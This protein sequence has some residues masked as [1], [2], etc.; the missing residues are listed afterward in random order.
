MHF[1][2]R[3]YGDGKPYGYWS[4]SQYRVFMRRIARMMSRDGEDFVNEER[5]QFVERVLVQMGWVAINE[6]Y[7]ALDAII[8]MGRG[9]L[10]RWITEY[11]E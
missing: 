2:P 7:E 10:R 3:I 8:A 5:A 9:D 11:R 4:R 1:H 6:G